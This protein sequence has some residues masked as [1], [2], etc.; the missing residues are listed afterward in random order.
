MRTSIGGALDYRQLAEMN[1]PTDPVALN[2]EARR[3]NA[4]G[5]KPRDISSHLGLHI[6]VVMRALNEK[7]GAA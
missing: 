4:Q 2:E 3:L 7:Q 6:E 1:R 5:L